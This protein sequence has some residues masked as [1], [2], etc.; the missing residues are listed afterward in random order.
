MD[1]NKLTIKTTMPG[2][3]ETEENGGENGGETEQGVAQAAAKFPS[4]SPVVLISTPPRSNWLSS[5]RTTERG[6]D[7]DIDSEDSLSEEEKANIN[8]IR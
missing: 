2:S 5:S 7:Y 1:N 6:F 4:P 8:P 3:F